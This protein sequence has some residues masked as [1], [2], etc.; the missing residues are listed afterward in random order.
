MSRK[1]WP[2]PGGWWPTLVTTVLTATGAAMT[3][4]STGSRISLA[5]AILAGLV[6]LFAAADVVRT[7]VCRRRARVAPSD[8]ADAR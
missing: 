6:G 1:F 4:I 2:E 8:P 7:P 5:I 3:A